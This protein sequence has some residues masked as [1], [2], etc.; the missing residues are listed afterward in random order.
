MIRCVVCDFTVGQCGVGFLKKH[1]AAVICARIAC[2]G[3]G[4]YVWRR[5]VAIYSSTMQR[6]C[7]IVCYET[8]DYYGTA[9]SVAADAPT[10][11]PGIV[12]GHGTAAYYGTC[13]IAVYGTSLVTGRI[14]TKSA[15]SQRGA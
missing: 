2:Y 8:I 12:A 7:A 3:T 4:G 13:L 1:P 15:A 14:A 9:T 6:V 10:P 5:L 11:G